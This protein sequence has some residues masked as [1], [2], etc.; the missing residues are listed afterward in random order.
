LTERGFQVIY[1]SGSLAEIKEW[2][3]ANIPC[4]LFVRTGD[5]PYWKLD[6]PHAIVVAGIESENLL[7]FDPA[8]DTA[9]I[10]VT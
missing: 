6:T 3:N 2:L 10:S 9:S 5:L 7:V 1:R 8:M 4:I